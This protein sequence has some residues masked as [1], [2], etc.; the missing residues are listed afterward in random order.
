MGYIL[1]IVASSAKAGEVHFSNNKSNEYSSC[2]LMGV[3][4]SVAK[5]IKKDGDV[6]VEHVKKV[7]PTFEGIEIPSVREK[8]KG[9]IN[10]E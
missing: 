5:T 7:C 2:V 4:T 8:G 6:E 10:K 1:Q 9:K 3:S